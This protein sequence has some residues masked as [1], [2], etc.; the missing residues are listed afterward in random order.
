MS[1]FSKLKPNGASGEEYN[2]KDAVA[3]Q[4]LQSTQNI[5]GNPL[6][7]TDAAHINAESLVV[8]LEP[9]QDLHGYEYPWLGGAGK[10][11]YTGSPSFDG[12]AQLNYWSKQ[13]ETYNGHEVY[14]RTEAWGGCYSLVTLPVGDYVFSCMVKTSDGASINIFNKLDGV[15]TAEVSS[16]TLFVQ[17]S[18]TWSKV[19]FAF[20]VTQAGTVAC[21]VE[22]GENGDVYISEYQL[23][24]DS[25]ATD[26]AP[27]ENICPLTGYDEVVVDDVGVNQWD[28]EWELGDLDSQGNPTPSST[29]IRSKNFISVVSSTTYYFKSNVI[30]YF[31]QYDANK[32]IIGIKF[33]VYAGTTFTTASNARYIKFILDGAYGTTYNHDI[34]I[35][36]PST[37][38]T[39]E[40]YHSS[41]ATIQFGQTVMGGSVDFK[42]G[43]VTVDREIVNPKDC[44]VAKNSGSATNYLYYLVASSLPESADLS[45]SDKWKSSHMRRYSSNDP[46]NFYPNSSFGVVYMNLG[47]VIG[48]NTVDG[49]KEYCTNN[50][51]Q[52]AYPIAAPFTIQLTPDELKLLKG[53]NHITTNGTTITLGYQPDNV[54]GEVKGEIQAIKEMPYL[55]ILDNDVDT[56]IKNYRLYYRFISA[57]YTLVNLEEMLRHRFIFVEVINNPSGTANHELLH[58]ALIDPR[59]IDGFEYGIDAGSGDT[60][61]IESIIAENKFAL[62]VRYTGSH[63][64]GDPTDYYVTIRMVD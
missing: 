29:L 4:Q 3:R 59:T 17:S 39:Y 30:G 45:N 33:N 5:S 22:R 62:S 2:V 50:N 53:T 27:Y 44:T 31:A 46:G 16:N 20:S 6:T 21:R 25:Q 58:S 24:S 11:K 1:D 26:Y 64:P 55:R 61:C 23:E 10:N 18:T 38:T 54:I 19:Q 8:E 49:F 7:I 52:I 32:I 42:T 13:T 34:S 35:N 41:N 60:I 12:F 47:D 37:V 28:E 14:K 40:P 15:T 36:Y 43:K 56:E 9:K 63:T 57:A 48:T 51:V